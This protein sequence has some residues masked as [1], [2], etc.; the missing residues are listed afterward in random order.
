MPEEK[1]YFGDGGKA[2]NYLLKHENEIYHNNFEKKIFSEFQKIVLCEQ[3]GGG[4]GQKEKEQ[5]GRI[6]TVACI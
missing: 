6:E 1:L 2:D 4:G 3:K 5:R